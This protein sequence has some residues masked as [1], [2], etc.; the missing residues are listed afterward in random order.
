MC[1]STFF[2]AYIECAVGIFVSVLR[3][4][5]GFV[6]L[7]SLLPI[8]VFDAIVNQWKFL[9]NR[10]WCR[11]HWKRHRCALSPEQFGSGRHSS[12]PRR[13]VSIISVRNMLVI[14][15]A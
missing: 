14:A 8:D 15:D 1:S 10:K 7:K 5:G 4:F 3:V 11:S 12:V 2:G 9:P 13:W 6:S